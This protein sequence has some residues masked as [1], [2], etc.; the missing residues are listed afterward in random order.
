M[1]KLNGYWVARLV[2]KWLI[3]VMF[4]LIA[5]SEQVIICNALAGIM[6]ILTIAYYLLIWQEIGNN[7]WQ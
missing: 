3:P 5:I 1:K 6:T 2:V 4:F 7:K